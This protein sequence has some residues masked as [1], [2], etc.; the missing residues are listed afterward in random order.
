M[1]EFDDFFLA[2]VDKNAAGTLT[3][4]EAIRGYYRLRS[5]KYAGRVV[6][7]CNGQRETVRVETKCDA[8]VDG[9]EES[10]VE[11]ETCSKCGGDCVTFKDV[12]DTKVWF[13]NGLTWCW[14]SAIADVLCESVSP[15]FSA[16]RHPIDYSQSTW[17][18]DGSDTPMH[19]EW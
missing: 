5:G 8:C 6:I 12:S 14:L 11:F 4:G 10:L 13:A 18:P 17:Y 3:I 19:Y 16:S 7:K 15:N 2:N 1:I 9:L